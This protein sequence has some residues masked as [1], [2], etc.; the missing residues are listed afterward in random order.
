MLVK[1][2]SYFYCI[3]FPK[4]TTAFN[5][6]EQNIFQQFYYRCFCFIIVYLPLELPSHKIVPDFT[7]S[8][9]IHH[10]T[11]LPPPFAFYLLPPVL[12]SSFS[13]FA[14][15]RSFSKFLLLFLYFIY[16]PILPSPFLFPLC[17]YLNWNPMHRI[18]SLIQIFFI[19]WIF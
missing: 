5:L 11:S 14:I 19:L 9:W 6:G 8:Q 16:L 13:F 3:L 15:F 4:Q 2:N 7:V 1:L 10:P 18:V 17:C 12:F